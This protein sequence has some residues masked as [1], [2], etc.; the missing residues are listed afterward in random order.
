MT[1]LHCDFVCF[2]LLDHFAL[3][4]FRDFDDG[5]LFQV[6]HCFWGD[7]VPQFLLPLCQDLMVVKVFRERCLLFHDS[8]Q[9]ELV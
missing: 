3:V 8:N 4:V 1:D 6:V 9:I 5:H 7:Q 2:Y